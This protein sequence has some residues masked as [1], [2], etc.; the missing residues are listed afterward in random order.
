MLHIEKLLVN[1]V[2]ALIIVFDPFTIRLLVKIFSESTV[3]TLMFGIPIRF[4]EYSAFDENIAIF[5]V[6]I[7]DP[8]KDVERILP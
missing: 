8:I 1:V 5:A 4:E 2:Y 7:R 6:P 3:L